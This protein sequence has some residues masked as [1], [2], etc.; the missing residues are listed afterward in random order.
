MK[1]ACPFRGFAECLVE[2]CMAWS[3]FDCRMFSVSPMFGMGNGNSVNHGADCIS[4]VVNP[5]AEKVTEVVKGLFTQEQLQGAAAMANQENTEEKQV[6]ENPVAKVTV[7]EIRVTKNGNIRVICRVE[8]GKED[9]VIIAKNGV[10][11]LFQ[12][13]LNKKFEI[14]YNVM[15]DGDAWFAI[16]AKQL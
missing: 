13:G 9:Q 7:M 2:N 4:T 1:K 8:N 16:K 6:K 3:G 11:K 14:E 10:G 5:E 15:K 12:E